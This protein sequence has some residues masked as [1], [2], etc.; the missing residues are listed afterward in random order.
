M[1]LQLHAY[2]ES[3]LGDPTRQSCKINQPPSRRDQN[4]FGGFFEIVFRDDLLRELPVVSV[5]DDEFY[6]IKIR[7]QSI[8]V[9]PMITFSFRRS[10]TLNIKNDLRARI[11][12]FR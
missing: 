1:K 7:A 12:F 8:Q 9:R 4:G 11:D 5:G 2:V 10:R 6:F 3:A